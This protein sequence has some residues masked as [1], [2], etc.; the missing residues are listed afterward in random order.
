MVLGFVLSVAAVVCDALALLFIGTTTIGV[1]GCMAIPINVFVSRFLL[2]EEIKSNEKIYIAV[3]TL[4]CVTSLVT[5][6]PHEPIETF[7]RFSKPE[8]AVY[9]TGVWLFS[10]ILVVASYLS[11]KREAQLLSLGVVSGIM[12]SQFVSMGKY[13]LDLTWLIRN[14]MVLPPRLQII[15]VI[16]ILS[17]SLPLQ[18][19]TLNKSL[20]KF[21]AT[22]S[23]AIFQCTWC[24]LN[25]VQGMVIFGDMENATAVQTVVFFFGFVLTCAGIV[26]LSKQIGAESR[27]YSVHN[28]SS[29]DF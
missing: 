20:E 10:A 26:G 6:Q 11:E 28:P 2:Y 25:V 13:L 18:I 3:I 9:I 12:G 8:T 29:T 24:V 23:V 7:I 21:N 4:G 19:I 14:D 17:V 27:S 22:H 16:F 15:G 5:T 1:L